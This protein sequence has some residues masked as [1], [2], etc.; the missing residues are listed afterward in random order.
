MNENKIKTYCFSSCIAFMLAFVVL[1]GLRLDVRAETK[2]AFPLPYGPGSNW[3]FSNP[4]EVRLPNDEDILGLVSQVETST[5]NTVYG[6]F[7]YE[8]ASD[9]SYVKFA[10]AFND[11]WFLMPNDTY[12]SMP[13]N[14]YMYLRTINTANTFNTQ[15]WRLDNNGA[16]YYDNFNL[17]SGTGTFFSG[18]VSSSDTFYIWYPF[19]HKDFAPVQVSS[20]WSTGREGFTYVGISGGGGFDAPGFITG[21]GTGTLDSDTGD[22]NIDF[23]L[24][25]D[26]SAIQGK[27]DTIIDNQE[28]SLEKQDTANNLLG[29]IW[30]AITDYFTPPTQQEVQTALNG[31]PVFGD[32][33]NTI[34]QTKTTVNSIFD[35]SQIQPKTAD[36]VDF[37]YDFTFVYYDPQ[38]HRLRDKVVTVHIVFSWFESIRTPVTLVL[39]VFLALGFLV[40]IF[41]QIPNLI[42][43]VGAGA[44]A[45]QSIADSV[46]NQK[47]G[48]SK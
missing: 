1:F 43:G 14:D 24:Q 6:F 42:N 26:D 47:G 21:E 17:D 41:R 23:N 7:I 29:R 3:G 31:F 38:F 32:L 48:G 40:Y 25:Y 5:G 35:F 28:G 45:G 8:I 27:L 33:T 44:S 19:Y 36:N 30:Q 22:L 15:I 18:G 34:G 2:N 46:T 9:Y 10:V 11:F 37:D 20:N 39:S 12:P 13:Y 4:N 16:F